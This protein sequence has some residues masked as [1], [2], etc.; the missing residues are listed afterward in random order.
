MNSEYFK[1]LDSEIN[2]LATALLPTDEQMAAD[3]YSDSLWQS[4]IKSFII[5]SHA[6]LEHYFEELAFSKCETAIQEFIKNQ[7]IS[8][9]LLSLILTYKVKWYREE[10]KSTLYITN[11]FQKI[12]KISFKNFTKPKSSSKNISSAVTK[13]ISNIL[14][15]LVK[16]YKSEI[17][18][19]NLGCSKQ[20][21]KSL[22]QP[23]VLDISLIRLDENLFSNIDTLVKKRGNYAHKCSAFWQSKPIGYQPA[24]TIES[25]QEWKKKILLLLKNPNDFDL[26]DFDDLITSLQ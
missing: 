14:E 26:A 24:I 23:L 16:A 18:D 4:Q 7:S 15:E 9:V 13:S 20:N 12:K 22:F 1:I 25:A 10:E 17:I 21:L 19:K 6:A 8:N 3:E 11:M 5:L 2:S